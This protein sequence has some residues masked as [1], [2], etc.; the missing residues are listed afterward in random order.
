MSTKKQKDANRENAKKSTGPKTTEGKETSAQNA[1]THGLTARNDVVKYESQ[2]DFDQYRHE[3]IEDLNPIGLM[4]QT[5]AERIISLS[6]RL[7]RAEGIQNQTI[8]IMLEK[9]ALKYPGKTTRKHLVTHVWDPNLALGRIA[10]IDFTNNK[11]LERLM[12]YERK[13][14]NS[15]YKTMK[16]LKNLKKEKTQNEPNHN[17]SNHG[18]RS[19]GHESRFMQNKPNFESKR[20]SAEGGP[21]HSSTHSPIHQKMQNEPNPHAHMNRNPDIIKDY[22][23]AQ[24]GELLQKYPKSEPVPTDRERAGNISPA[25]CESNSPINRS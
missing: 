1:V 12:T 24:P 20:S 4:Q 14:E 13:I 5:L 21:I 2:D 9:D 25:H 6:W 16:E 23:N 18:S 17:H 7:K 11:L 3:M 15:L 19:T 10:E 8:D 22:E